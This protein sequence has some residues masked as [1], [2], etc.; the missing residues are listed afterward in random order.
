[1]IGI[2]AAPARFLLAR[3]RVIGVDIRKEIFHLI[4][5]ASTGR[6]PSEVDQAGNLTPRST[7]YRAATQRLKEPKGRELWEDE[8]VH[9]LQPESQ[10]GLLIL[11]CS[12]HLPRDNLPVFFLLD[13][14]HCPPKVDRTERLSA[15]RPLER[16]QK[17]NDHRIPVHMY[18]FLFDVN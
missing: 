12:R 6:L 8:A 2:G 1:M 15:E 10:H 11:W 14:N 5:L 16:E 9:T 18:L 13:P 3:R 4:E 7:E 17:V